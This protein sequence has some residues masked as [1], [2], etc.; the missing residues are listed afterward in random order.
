M[1]KSS[2]FGFTL[3]EVL[4]T[5]GIIGVVAALTIPNMIQNSRN[6]EFQVQL[7]KVYSEWNQISM[8]YMNDHEESIPEAVAEEYAKN[9]NAKIFSQELLKYI[10]GVNKFSDW[11]WTTKDEDGNN[12]SV[13][14]QPY[15]TYNLSGNAI[16]LP[17]DSSV[18]DGMSIDIGGKLFKFDDPPS[19]GKNGPRLCVDLNGSRKPNVFGIDI[20]SFI[21]TTD[22]HIIPEGQ[23]HKDSSYKGIGAVGNW[24]NTVSVLEGTDYCTVNRITCAYYALNDKNPLGA[25]TYWKDYIGKKLYKK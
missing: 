20:F 6:K 16:K 5:L 21:F 7:K 9:Y 2:T 17:C 12:N 23:P 22:G 10:K 15:K 3:A 19:Q 11:N 24:G 25:G 18:Y 1:K 4:I 14:A 13:N 8:Q